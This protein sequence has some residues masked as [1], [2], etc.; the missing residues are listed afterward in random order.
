MT[1][2]ESVRYSLEWWQIFCGGVCTIAIFSFLVKENPLY[3][4][5]EHFFIG[6]A[7]SW[8]TIAT[9]REFLWPKVLKPLFGLDRPLLPGGGY[10]VP[11]NSMNL[12]FLLPMLFGSL[13][14]FVSSKRHAWLAQLVIGFSFGV[15]GGLAFQGIFSEMLP[16]IF[17][18]FRPLWV[19]DDPW[20][21]VS[22]LIFILTLLTAFSY[23]IFTFKRQKGGVMER[24]S[25]IGR[26]MMM[27]CFGAFF[28]STIMARMALLVERL[29]FLIH[30]WIPLITKIG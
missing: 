21:A 13:Y 9:L 22:N 29:D 6:I 15:S 26:W 28:G 1:E 24:S 4:I 14:Y 17:D 7:V 18:S 20:K 11:Y 8:G 23:F 2:T 27:G 25:T 12:L 10:A 5:F 19:P 30:S 16:Q 3:R